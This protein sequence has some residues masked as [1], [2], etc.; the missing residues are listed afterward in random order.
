MKFAVKGLAVLAGALLLMGAV[1]VTP[2]SADGAKRCTLVSDI[3]K[4]G[5]RL[6]HELFGW[7]KRDHKR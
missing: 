5:Q 2:A 3:D 7:M 4:L 1:A 6:D